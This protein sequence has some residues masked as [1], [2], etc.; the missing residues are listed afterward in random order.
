[1][2]SRLSVARVET[3]LNLLLFRPPPLEVLL[4]CSDEFLLSVLLGPANIEDGVNTT[5]F[6]VNKGA[7]FDLVNVHSV[8][9]V[10]ANESDESSAGREASSL[11]RSLSLVKL[12]SLNLF[13]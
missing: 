4:S 12:E 7:V 6:H 5:L 9:V 8:I 1:M 11:D 13:A 3:L 10:M 2:G